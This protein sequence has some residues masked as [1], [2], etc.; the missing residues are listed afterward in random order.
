MWVADGM[1]GSRVNSRAE[2]VAARS[3]VIAGYDLAYCF[4]FEVCVGCGLI[5]EQTE[6][7]VLRVE[8]HE[9]GA[10]TGALVM[11]HRMPVV[12]HR[13]LDERRRHRREVVVALH[14]EIP[15]PVWQ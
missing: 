10:A 5:V 12:G 3:R 7:F 13:E 9:V 15:H 1:P 11:R 2:V 8:S 14:V 4:G 6:R